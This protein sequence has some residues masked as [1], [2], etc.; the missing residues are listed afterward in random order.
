M[1]NTL[2]SAIPS[3]FDACP[4]TKECFIDSLQRFAYNLVKGS[5]LLVVA[6]AI[7][8]IT[9]CVFANLREQIN[10]TGLFGDLFISNDSPGTMGAFLTTSLFFNCIVN[11]KMNM[12]YPNLSGFVFTALSVGF[13]NSLD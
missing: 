9:G 4:A 8:G 10:S 5:A 11:H 2:P 13:F 7:T 6:I 1:T 3:V 12:P